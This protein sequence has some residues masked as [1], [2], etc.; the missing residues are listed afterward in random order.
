[1]SLSRV[2]VAGRNNHGVT[3]QPAEVQQIMQEV[4]SLEQRLM[5][6]TRLGIVLTERMGGE[7]TVPVADFDEA[8]KTELGVRWKEDKDGIEVRIVKAEGEERHSVGVSSVPSEDMAT[9]DSAAGGTPVPEETSGAEG[10]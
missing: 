5:V 2:I 6:L 3:L 7:Y 9:P 4:W 10:E 8:E 1:M